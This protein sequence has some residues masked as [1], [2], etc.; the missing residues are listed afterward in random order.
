[1]KPNQT[2]WIV[3]D[4]DGEYLGYTKDRFEKWSID[5]FVV[6]N[7]EKTWEE[8]KKQGYKCVK[9]EVREVK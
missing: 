8:H 1:M 9:V 4:P 7:R 2:F 6:W 5:E 3:K